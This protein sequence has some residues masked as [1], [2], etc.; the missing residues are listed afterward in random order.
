MPYKHDASLKAKLAELEAATKA[1][2]QA[3]QNVARERAP[4]AK[5]ICNLK[6]YLERAQATRHKMVHGNGVC[7]P[8]DER[9]AESLHGSRWREN[10]ARIAEIKSQLLDAEIAL[11]F[12]D[13]EHHT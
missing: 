11:A 8:Q 12:F 2:K 1:L 4:L 10:V 6:R 7:I 3:A 5:R 13:K 9:T